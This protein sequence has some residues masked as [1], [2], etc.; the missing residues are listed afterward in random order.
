MLT[1]KRK[2]GFFLNYIDN[3]PK[4]VKCTSIARTTIRCGIDLV[5]ISD[6][7]FSQL[8][9]TL[10]VHP[11]PW[12]IGWDQQDNLLV[13]QYVGMHTVIHYV[14]YREAREDIYWAMLQ[15]IDGLSWYRDF[16]L[17]DTMVV[18]PSYLYI[19]NSY[20]CKMATSYLHFSLVT[21]ELYGHFRCLH[22]GPLFQIK[23]HLLNTILLSG[24]QSSW[25]AL[26]NTE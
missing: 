3:E 16:H 12:F 20:T 17:R 15:Y 13:Y 10:H 14:L 22:L 5:G 2:D 19:V 24:F 26:E 18:R 8:V 6:P 11:L 21:F 1:F 7:Q 4:C 9:A 25:G 23:L